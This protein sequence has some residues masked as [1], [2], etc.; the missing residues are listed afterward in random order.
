[1]FSVLP[2]HKHPEYLQ[3]C[4]KLINSEWKRSD[5]ARL[6][7]LESSCDQL[8]VSLILLRQNKLLGHLKLSPIPSIKDGCFVES[9]VIDTHERGKGYGSLFMDKAE[10]YCRSHLKLNAIYLSTKGQEGFY[11]KLGYIK[12]SPISIYGSIT[13]PAVSYLNN[14]S[15]RK[16]SI[17]TTTNVPVAPP[18]PNKTLGELGKN[19]KTYM[20]KKL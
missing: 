3:D 15:P 9:V 7:S 10:Q 20:T 18:M 17:T 13:P 12:C 5:T 4:C 14:G 6:R 16:F 1:M 2:L 19:L 11:S 8:P